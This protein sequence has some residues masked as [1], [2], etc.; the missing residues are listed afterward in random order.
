MTPDERALSTPQASEALGAAVGRALQPGE[1][2]CLWGPLGA[3]KTTLARGLIRAL[4][5]EEEVPSPTFT[6]VQ[7][8]DGG[9]FPIAHFDLYRIEHAAEIE[10]LGLEEAL[11][12]G[13]AVIEWPE[14]LGAR[15]PKDRLDIRL[16]IQGEGRRARL[17]RHGRWH[18]RIIDY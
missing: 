2:V 9:G 1:A 12:D 8:Y 3:G 13:A 14:R 7:A 5:G 15:L 4:A 6:L 10:E 17:E 18:G 11:E 16:E